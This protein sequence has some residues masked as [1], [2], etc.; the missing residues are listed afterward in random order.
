M[1]FDL[2]TK[3]LHHETYST[4]TLRL[5]RKNNLVEVKTAELNKGERICRLADGVMVGKWRDKSDVAFITTELLNEVTT[6]CNKR[7]EEK[8]MPTAIFHYNKNMGGVDRQ[9]QMTS[10]YPF[11][12]RTLRWYKKLGTHIFQLLLLHAHTMYNK[13]TNAKKL[14][15]YDFRLK[16][17]A[18]LLP[19]KPPPPKLTK[20]HFPEKYPLTAST[21]R[22][23]RKRC[24][25]C[26]RQNIRK[27]TMYFCRGC[28]NFPPLCIE[29]F[30][31]FHQ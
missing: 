25:N 30:P 3:L 13:Y 21:K 1:D 20:F 28:V 7:N 12:R 9:D 27:D 16:V 19:L 11:Y 6:Y 29:C 26:S 17:I 5:D 18:T 24:Q 23:A 10:Y 31:Q 4:G 2:S 15:F 22:G 14:S 8:S